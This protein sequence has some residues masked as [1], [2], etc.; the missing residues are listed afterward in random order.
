M[1]RLASRLTLRWIA[2]VVVLGGTAVLAWDWIDAVPAEGAA[3]PTYV[4]RETCGKWHQAQYHSWLGSDHDRAMD[5]ATD[6]TVLAD[7]N[8]TKFEYQGVT[9]RFFR[10]GQKF[11]VNTEGP[12]A[13]FHDYEVKYTFGVRPLQQYMIEFP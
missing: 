10:N 1:R 13:K 5:M 8:D 3:N 7:F 2:A 12:D 6:K 11:I 4:G 9:T